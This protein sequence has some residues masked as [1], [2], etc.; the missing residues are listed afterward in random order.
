MSLLV[1]PQALLR[2]ALAAAGR[3]WYVFPVAV[4]AKWPALH[5]ARACTGVGP[6]GSGHLGWE[7][8]ATRDPRRIE[9]CWAAAPYNIGIAAGPSGLVVSDLD[10]RKPHQVPP[11]GY[12]HHTNGAAVLR[13]LCA[14]AGQPYP[15]HT[16]TVTTGRGGEHLYF[17][18]PTGEPQLRNTA[19]GTPGA[20]GWLIDTRAHGGYVLGAGS[21]VDGRLYTTTLD[22]DPAPLPSW[23]AQ[24]L[25]PTP[26]P[27]RRPVV[28]ALPADRRGSYLR[29]AVERECRHVAEATSGRN[30]ALYGAAVALGQLVAGGELPADYVTDALTTAAEAC[31][32]HR[33]PPPGQIARSIHSG[34]RAG[35]RRPRR[36]AV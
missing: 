34:L 23:L 14:S 12:E 5:G 20:L 6:C 1:D 19:S 4:N 8:R 13:D 22:R 33:D 27:P 7:Q 24:R 32:L 15:D 16:H 3:G 36:V 35:A 30:R 31:G 29:T 28:V 11:P 21:V 26:L 17:A 10:T 18:H 2:S 9:R 25:T